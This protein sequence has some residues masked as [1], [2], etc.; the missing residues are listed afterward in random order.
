LGCELPV[1]TT[2]GTFCERLLRSGDNVLLCPP[3]GLAAMVSAIKAMMDDAN[4]R[5]RLRFEANRTKITPA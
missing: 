3:R 4:L 5:E 1:V 2:Q